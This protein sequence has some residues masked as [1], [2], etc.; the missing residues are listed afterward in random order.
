MTRPRSEKIDLSST[1]YY[2]VVS[3]C[4][5]RTYLCGV[6]RETGYDY[7]HRKG[8]IESKI[9]QLSEAFSIGICAYAIMSNHYHLVL[10]VDTDLALS[11]E[12]E[13]IYRRWSMIF[14][15]D[16]EHFKRL[17]PT[18][19]QIQAKISLWRER[20]QSISWF[21]RCLN[22]TIAREANLEDELTGRFWEGRFKSQALLD[23]GALLSAMVYVDLNP[24]RAKIADTPETSEFTSIYERIQKVLKEK[25]QKPH[26][27]LKSLKQP[28]NLV[29]FG[30]QS[31]EEATPTIDFSLKD[32]LEL[33]DKTGRCLRQDKRGAI[34]E[35]LNPI[36][37]RLNINAEHWVEMIKMLETGFYSA[38][39]TERVLTNFQPHL[40]KRR[41][42]GVRQ[43]RYFY[44]AA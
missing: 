20:L 3:R 19:A 39:G 13:E 33:V 16:A 35:S 1:A 41:P 17:T 36:L 9:K 29:P 8:W 2:H 5:R 23:E 31:Q 28:K 26:I 22:E 40:R 30:Y 34:D 7:S 42:K 37:D 18:E 44:Q 27:P 4:V 21:M 11:F 14:P 15:K 6:D 43:A 25:A 12:D 38:I 10:H 32:Y 24:I